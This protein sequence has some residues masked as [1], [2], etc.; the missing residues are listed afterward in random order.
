[1]IY[2]LPTQSGDFQTRLQ[3]LRLVINRQNSPYLF[4]VVQQ[5][6]TD[7]QTLLQKL[8]AITGSG[9]EGLMLR[10]AKSAHKAGRTSD[11]LKLKKFQDA[12]ASVIK[13]NPGKG[14][15][16]GMMGSITVRDQAGRIF[17]IGTGFSDH[18]RRQPPP[19]GT[20]ISFKYHGHYQSGT[21]RFPVFWRSRAILKPDTQPSTSPT[22]QTEAI[23]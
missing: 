6:I 21:P 17:R 9:G 8:D 3:Q 20:T 15:Y 5:K 13:H 16:R 2:D 10:R 14:K 1:M 23:P 19:P 7:Q 12:E 4:L 18:E 11:L 22:L